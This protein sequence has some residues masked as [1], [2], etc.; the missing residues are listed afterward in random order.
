CRCVPKR[1][2]P[3]AAVLRLCQQQALDDVAWHS[4]DSPLRNWCDHARSWSH[5]RLT[6]TSLPAH[7]GRMTRRVRLAPMELCVFGPVEARTPS[8]PITFTRARERAV[9]ATL[10]LFHGRAV[11][12]DRLVDAVWGDGPPLRPEKAIQTHVQRLRTALGASVIETHSDGY[13]LT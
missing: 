12:T 10:A 5:A 1:R 11:S 9:L 13:A 2:N 3:S 8:G 7:S 4:A 6:L